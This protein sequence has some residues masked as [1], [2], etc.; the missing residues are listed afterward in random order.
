[1][2]ANPAAT[3][4]LFH[5]TFGEKP[6]VI[7]RAP[8]R[9]NLIGEHIDYN[10]GLVLPLAISRTL[11]L[12][13]RP[14]ADGV[15][16]A[17]STNGERA[18]INL[19]DPD[20]PE[21]GHW[22]RYGFGMARALTNAGVELQG[23]DVTITSTIPA[24]SGLSS[25][26]ALELALGL[27]LLEFRLRE[28]PVISR[29]EL[30]QLARQ[31]EVETVGVNCGIM[32]QFIC[33]MGQA[34]HALLLDTRTLEYRHVPLSSEKARVV[35]VDSRV[36]RTLA[37][38]AYNQ[39]RA[40]CEDARQILQEQLG[41]PLED[42][43]SVTPPELRSG[44]SSLSSPLDKRA[45][46]VVGEEA[47]VMA[48]VEALEAVDLVSVGARMN[49]SHASLR[50]FYE[51]SVPELDLLAELAQQTQGVFGARLTG[52]GF[53][54][55]TVNLVAPDAI[56]SFRRHVTTEYQKATGLKPLVYACQAVSGASL[57][58]IT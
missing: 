49:E 44:L 12:A 45:Q 19:A 40:E 39:R 13:A 3:I 7:A 28:R 51:V 16:R 43:C 31:A 47:R 18:Q 15:I 37:D 38:S 34:G 11:W 32:D 17:V 42:L 52:A 26:A 27:A 36:P 48:A 24:G 25:S 54:G 30:A 22:L 58:H 33:A 56:G 20:G 57:K 35:V 55:C 50:D 9:V 23:M 8:G 2:P 29:P 10:G 14:R 6:T 53:G 41:R 21:A 46:H 1:M 4:R 5:E